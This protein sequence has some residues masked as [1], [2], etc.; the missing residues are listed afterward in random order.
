MRRVHV[1]QSVRLL[2]GLR[3]EL[4][5]GQLHLRADGARDGW[6]YAVL[7]EHQVRERSGRL[8]LPAGGG[9]CVVRY[10]Q[11]GRATEADL[12]VVDGSVTELAPGG[13]LQARLRCRKRFAE[14]AAA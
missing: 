2:P 5:A 14:T 4:D 11:E 7:V 1:G 3:V 13:P 9:R 8:S 6:A 12:V 10:L